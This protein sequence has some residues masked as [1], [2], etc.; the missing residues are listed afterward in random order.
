MGV[1]TF[2]ERLTGILKLDDPNVVLEE[3]NENNTVV[4]D[5]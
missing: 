5:E 4:D 2:Y 1:E 3:E